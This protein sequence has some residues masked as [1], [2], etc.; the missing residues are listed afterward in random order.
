M[1]IPLSLPQ[2]RRSLKEIVLLQVSRGLGDPG[3]TVF[4][5]ISQ[6]RAEAKR[7]V[8]ADEQWKTVQEEDRP[9][10]RSR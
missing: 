5:M 6:N 3:A 2:E 4:V 1:P 10:A 8:I 7:E 9:S